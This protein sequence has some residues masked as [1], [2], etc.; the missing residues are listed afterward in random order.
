MDFMRAADEFAW[1]KDEE[2]ARQMLA[3][4]DPVIIQRLQVTTKALAS[5]SSFI[6]V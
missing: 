3:G 1:R 4:V 5:P 2:F 6:I